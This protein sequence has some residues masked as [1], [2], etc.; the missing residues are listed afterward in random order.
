MPTRAAAM[1]WLSMSVANICTLKLCFSVSCRSASR[2]AREY[3]SSPVEQPGTQIRI[4]VST[5]LPANNLGM[6]CCSR[7]LKASGSRKKL[8]TP[9]NMSRNKA[10]TSSGVCW[11]NLK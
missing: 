2:M 8:V 1:A 4:A 7:N 6:I 10:S 9:I 5:L 3:A 11:P